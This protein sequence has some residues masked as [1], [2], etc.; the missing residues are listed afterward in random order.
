M[1]DRPPEYTYFLFASPYNF[2]LHDIF[3]PL[4]GSLGNYLPA[5]VHIVSFIMLTAGIMHS[6]RKGNF[7]I[8]LFWLLLAGSCELGQKFPEAATQ[9]IPQ[10]FD[11]I[12]LL[13]NTWNYFTHGTYCSIDLLATFLGALSGYWI[14]TLTQNRRTVP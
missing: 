1:I 2:S 5:F 4:F 12:F 13:E 14:L 8:C 3:P 6:G 10:W 7:V 9:L 11:N